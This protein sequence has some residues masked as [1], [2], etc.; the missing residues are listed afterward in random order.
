M[1]DAEVDRIYDEILAAPFI[2]PM[3]RIFGRAHYSEQAGRPLTDDE[4]DTLIM[5][6]STPDGWIPDDDRKRIREG[7]LLGG[8]GDTNA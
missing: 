1:Q 3:L 6:D 8:G 5:L 4:V 2:N 7:I